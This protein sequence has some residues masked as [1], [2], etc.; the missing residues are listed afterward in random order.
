MVV[1]ERPTAVSGIV[2]W[3]DGTRGYGFLV[4]DDGG[5]DVLIHFSVLR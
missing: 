3:F 1:S 5:G 2:K 4:P